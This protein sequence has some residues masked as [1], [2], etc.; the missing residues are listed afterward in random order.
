M[1]EITGDIWTIE[2]DFLCITT[3]GVVKRNGELVMGKGIAK[4]AATRFPG[5]ATELGTLVMCS[6]NHVYVAWHCGSLYKAGS[7]LSFPTKH[8]FR[9][10][11]DLALIEQSCVELRSLMEHYKNR[12]KKDVTVVL[13][14]PGCGCG[15]LDWEKDVK[16]ILEKHFPENNVIVCQKS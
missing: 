14:R 15:G 3:N 11:S 1:K 9:H 5:I 7:L 16:Q 4:E 2:C 13:P 8:D 12:L 6:G 10:K